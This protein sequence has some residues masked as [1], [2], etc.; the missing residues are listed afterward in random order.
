MR[1]FKGTLYGAPPLDNLRFKAPAALENWSGVKE[2]KAFGPVHAGG[3]GR[4]YLTLRRPRRLA[5][6]VTAGRKGYTPVVLTS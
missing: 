2:T 5:A 4:R 6:R 1:V 3:A